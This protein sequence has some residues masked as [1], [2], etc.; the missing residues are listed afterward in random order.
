MEVLLVIGCKQRRLY[1]GD[2]RFN[3]SLRYVL[4]GTKLVVVLTAS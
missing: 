4:H 3:P 1:H 2:T